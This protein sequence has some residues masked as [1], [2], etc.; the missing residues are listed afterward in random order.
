MA[1]NASTAAAR[2]AQ[3]LG[4]AREKITEGV[5]AVSTPP[6]QLA[7]R[8]KALYVANVNA[9]ADV[10]AK[11]VAAV[12]LQTWKDDMLG[13]GLDRIATGATAAVPRFEAFLAKLIP[14]INAAKAS[15]PPRGNFEQNLARSAAMARALHGQSFK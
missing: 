15:L 1:A 7:S 6:G 11:N 4:A 3:N 10:W 13:K 5:N 12:P 9:R 8:Q 14:A 2:W